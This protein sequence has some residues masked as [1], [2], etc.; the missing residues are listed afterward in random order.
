M[1]GKR[2]VVGSFLLL[3]GV[4]LLAGGISYW[5]T[6]ELWSR[7][8]NERLTKDIARMEVDL[9]RAGVYEGVYEGS[10][11]EK[12][13]KEVVIRIDPPLQG[14]Q[15]LKAVFSKYAGR[16]VLQRADCSDVQLLIALD[17]HALS[18]EKI[19]GSFEDGGM[20]GGRYQCRLYVD[21]P[22]PG[23]AGRKQLLT[24]RHSAPPDLGTHFTVMLLAAPISGLGLLLTFVGIVLRAAQSGEFR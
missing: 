22:A 1:A 23:L 7:A 8:R 21:K 10:A 19:Y 11:G 3:V 18:G 16:M 13:V 2:R 20:L 15:S 4:L 14:R 9:S 24:I 6:L 5:V 17:V 12:G